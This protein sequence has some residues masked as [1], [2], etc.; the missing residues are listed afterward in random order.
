MVSTGSGNAVSA[1][2]NGVHYIDGARVIDY[3]PSSLNAVPS[4]RYYLWLMAPALILLAA[5][6]LY[7]FFSSSG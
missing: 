3:S 1:A 6:S 2:H 4:S 5:I 7:P